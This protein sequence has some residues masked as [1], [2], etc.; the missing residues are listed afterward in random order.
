MKPCRIGHC[1]I[2]A[3]D[4]RREDGTQPAD[5]M[6]LRA[7]IRLEAVDGSQLN[8]ASILEYCPALGHW[9]IT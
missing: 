7:E 9:V 6:E 5:V 3:E 2:A 4:L 1:T 8:E